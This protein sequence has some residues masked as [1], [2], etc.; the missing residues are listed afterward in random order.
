[1]TFGSTHGWSGFFLLSFFRKSRDFL[2]KL[3]MILIVRIGGDSGD[4][5]VLVLGS[6]GYSRP[7][8]SLTM[9]ASMPRRRLACI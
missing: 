6:S 9:S 7:V 1:V 3:V 5:G 2:G 4:G 8:L